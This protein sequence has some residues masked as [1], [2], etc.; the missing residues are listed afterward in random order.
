MCARP[1][2]GS[3]CGLVGKPQASLRWQMG[4]GEWCCSEWGL[5]GQ[6]SRWDECGAEGS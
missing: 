2:V 3:M 5:Q 1:V 4:I 6:R